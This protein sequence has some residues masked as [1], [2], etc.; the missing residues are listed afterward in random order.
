MGLD[1][2]SENTLS[3]EGRGLAF[4]SSSLLIT[5]TPHKLPSS[6]VKNVKEITLLSRFRHRLQAPDGRK[7]RG[8][9]L[10]PG[11]NV[12]IRDG[13]VG[14]SGGEVGSYPSRHL[15]S[16][17]FLLGLEPCPWLTLRS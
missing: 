1:V 8:R 11:L 9:R 2:V 5:L 10:S 14:G 13:G 17:G 16:W 6:Q 3:S 7:M 15:D 4:M 12:A